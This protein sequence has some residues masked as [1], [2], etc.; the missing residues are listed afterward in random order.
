M[1]MTS[2]KSAL[3]YALPVCLAALAVSAGAAT[4]TPRPLVHGPRP[5][6]AHPA[7]T[8]LP[9]RLGVPP[10]G[11]VLKT[12]ADIR[13]LYEQPSRRT[14][15]Q[16]TSVTLSTWLAQQ[17]AGIGGAIDHEI[18]PS[19]PVFVVNFRYPN[20]Y[21]FAGEERGPDATAFSIVDAVTGAPL[22]FQIKGTRTRR[23]VPPAPRH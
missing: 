23:N 11:T 4:P 13:A 3:Q 17:A 19:R 14:G 21:H 20:G 10:A 6:H 1:K 5:T 8:T 9:Y 15:A 18:A 2:S 7:M 16:I 12:E 22:S